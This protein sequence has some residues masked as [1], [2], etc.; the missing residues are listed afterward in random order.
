MQGF[1]TIQTISP[2]ENF[3]FM[4]NRVK[5]PVEAV[6][7]YRL[8]LDIGHH[9][10]LL[11]ILYVP[12]LSRNLISLSKLDVIGYSFNFGDECF[13]LFQHNHLIS[14]SV[15]CDGLYKLKL[16][17]LYAGTILTLHHNVGTKCSLVNE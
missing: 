7:T 12:S 6:E 14:M 3:V 4:G 11:E 16:D 10:D 8:N 5:A 2:N 1:L 9:L 17:G 15:L 13:N